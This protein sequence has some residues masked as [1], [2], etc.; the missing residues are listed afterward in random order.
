MKD[1]RGRGKSLTLCEMM[2]KTS[3]PG[4]CTCNPCCQV[5]AN[6]GRYLC[7]TMDAKDYIW[8]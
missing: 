5:V 8:Q 4:L 3:H 1:G 2:E 6:P 7:M